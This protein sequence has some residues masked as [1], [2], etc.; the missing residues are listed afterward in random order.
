MEPGYCTIRNLSIAVPHWTYCKNWHSREANPEGPVFS[1]IYDEGYRRVPWLSHTA[2]ETG[3]DAMCVT[4]GIASGNGIGISLGTERF[5]F[6]GL[7][8]YL[9][10]RELH[11]IARVRKCVD[12]GEKAYSEMYETRSPSG[13]YS[14]A[15]DCFTEAMGLAS[16]LELAKEE[17]EISERLEHIKNV[18]RSQF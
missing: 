3:I 12:F 17:R 18:F 11:L 6:C 2:P 9:A 7:A 5:E 15:K 8:H 13:S 10:W 14:D 1:S 16:E 4:C